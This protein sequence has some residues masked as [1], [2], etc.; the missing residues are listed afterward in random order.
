MQAQDHVNKNINYLFIQITTKF[1][2]KSKGKLELL[3]IYAFKKITKQKK[4][5]LAR[6][7]WKD[8]QNYHILENFFFQQ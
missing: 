6:R 7:R 8:S 2:C 1:T 5:V 4:K 3:S